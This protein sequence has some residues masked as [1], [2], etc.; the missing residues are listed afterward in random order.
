M[1]PTEP[2]HI[3]LVIPF[4]QPLTATDEAMAEVCKRAYIP[5]L[6]A[7]ERA[8][9]LRLGLH[10]TGHVLDYLARN[11]EG[12]LLRIKA[13]TKRGQ[14]EILGGLF[15]GGVPALLP[16]LD[17]R[18]QLEM[19]GEFWDSYIGVVPKGFWLSELAWTP[20]L[21]RLL[22]D[23]GLEYGFI[24]SGQL[25]MDTGRQRSL[26]CVERG[27]QRIAAFVLDTALSTALPARPVEEWMDAACARGGKN[28]H[29]LLNVWVRAESLGV[30]PG[31]ARW[32]YEEGWLDRWFSALS[33]S[34]ELET[35]LPAGTYPAVHGVEPLRL[36]NMCAPELHALGET[37]AVIDWSDF[38]FV[39]PE[40][41]TMYRRMLRASEKLREAIGIMEDEA[42]EETWSDKL[43]TA[44]RLVFA[45]QAPDAYWRGAAPGFSDP[46][47]RDA[48]MA[49]LLRAES[50][51]DSLVQG[52]EDW[53]STEEAD[54]DA[55]LSE[56]VFVSTRHLMAWVAPGRG[57]D[58]RTLDDRA[59]ERNVLDT[60]SR[61][62]EPFFAE[63]AKAEV[64]SG[65]A[66]GPPK[67][68]E[69]LTRP[70]SDLPTESDQGARRG[71]RQ[72]IVEDGTSAAEFMSGSAVDLSPARVSWDVLSNGIDE[73]GDCS[74][75][76]SLSGDMALGG[77]QR[78]Q[79]HIEKDLEVPI[80]AP[81][82]RLRCKL[83]LE[84]GPAV[85]WA[86][87]IPV[88]LGIGG[89]RLLADGE[90]VPPARQDLHGVRKA[91]LEAADGAAVELGFSAP[92]DI[93]WMPLRTTL[94]DLEGYRPI[95]Q[96]L[97]IVPS[98]LVQEEAALD[99]TLRLTARAL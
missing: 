21:P 33:E 97:L 56:E 61:R 52:E 60:G 71:M 69:A 17:V 64:R 78:R 49:R 92:T 15:Y 77:L 8:E 9:N 38:P 40:V 50:M 80:D 18:G 4:H 65:E 37:D 74:Y 26:G 83:Q 34:P 41:D 86:L 45:A 30:E 70:A 39:Y 43:A 23:S 10:F 12:L 84:G 20:E 67:R 59:S 46:A 95:E 14:V 94:R 44:Q 3:Q 35:V 68:G 24:A 72:W 29:R 53:L 58:I 27:G 25:H 51:I 47:V 62:A 5:L 28:A 85:R 36:G 89:L 42:L 7:I 90:A 2:I 66:A 87:E 63:M 16:E 93:W 82:L 6:E 73:E 54:L 48:T 91:R 79:L 57:G 1:H 81:E 98:I 96:G 32:C 13:L 76:L 19:S 75:T 55:D 31:T 11:Q 88:R 22:E 99:I